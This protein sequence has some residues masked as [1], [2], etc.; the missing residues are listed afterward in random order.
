MSNPRAFALY[1]R[2]GYE[3]QDKEPVEDRWD[4]VDGDGVRHRGVEFVV[5]MRKALEGPCCAR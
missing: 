4:F 2:L 3:P 5:H 1:Q